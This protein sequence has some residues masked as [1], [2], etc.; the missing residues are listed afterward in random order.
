[1]NILDILNIISEENSKNKKIEL[2]KKYKSNK[3]FI[4]VLKL[5]YDPN[6]IYRIKDVDIDIKSTGE[7]ELLN[8]LDLL[9]DISNRKYVGNK[10]IDQVRYMLAKLD[11]DDEVVIKRILDRNLKLDCNI[12]TINKAIP[13]LIP[14]TPYMGAVTFDKEKILNVIKDN[15]MV[16][17]DVK[18]D[19][20]YVNIIVHDNIVEMVSRQ[21]KPSFINNKKLINTAKYTAIYLAKNNNIDDGIVFNGELMLEGYSRYEANGILNSI[22]KITEKELAGENIE[23]DLEKFKKKHGDF[24]KIVDKVYVTVWDFLPYKFYKENKPWKKIRKKRL[25]ILE[26]SMPV[27]TDVIRLVEYKFLHSYKGIMTYFK[28]LLNK[29]EEGVIVKSLKGIWE[30]KKPVYQIK[31]KLEFT[32]NLKIV[33]FN[34]GKKGTKYANTLGSLQCESSDGLLKADASGIKDDKRDLIW[35]SRDE[36]LNSI[37]EIKCNGLSQDKEGNY[38]LLHPVYKILR[39]DSDADSLEDI[40]NNQNMVLGLKGE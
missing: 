24:E 32:I 40:I 19:G 33:G 13:N 1:M 5:A 4:R 35:N 22:I 28:E 34:P 18:M 31:M 8:G 25:E 14:V 21:G 30:N 3:L 9:E 16:E 26:K 23:K 11:H 2:I 20:R 6:Y 36:L 29:G 27:L 39:D 12:S 37:V 38:S 15:D 17:V 7:Y 10:A